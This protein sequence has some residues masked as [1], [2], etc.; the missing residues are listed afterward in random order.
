MVNSNYA[1]VVETV[2]LACGRTELPRNVSGQFSARYTSSRL[3]CGLT[4]TAASIGPSV[5]AK[6][7]ARV[8]TRCTGAAIKLYVA[9]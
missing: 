5:D 2:L 8:A 4:K 9:A 3:R 1:T 6:M 7:L